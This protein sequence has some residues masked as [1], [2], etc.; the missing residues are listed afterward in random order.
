[1]P[2]Y[3]SLQKDKH[4]SKHV[5]LKKKKTL[6]CCVFSRSTYLLYLAY[7]SESIYHVCSSIFLLL[8][9]NEGICRLATR[10]SKHS[11]CNHIAFHL[12]YLMN[13][14]HVIK[15]TSFTTPWVSQIL[16]HLTIINI[17]FPATAAHSSEEWGGSGQH[18]VWPLADLTCYGLWISNDND[19]RLASCNVFVYHANARRHSILGGDSTGLTSV[20]VLAL[21]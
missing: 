13:K 6:L 3:I 20:A 11:V 9:K 17:P 14:L 18:E 12:M 16:L 7:Y 5:Y 8:C 1:M 10:G 19:D 2:V 15:T 21:Y 4:M